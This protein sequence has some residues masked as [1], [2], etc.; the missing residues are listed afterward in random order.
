MDIDVIIA[1]VIRFSSG[2]SETDAGVFGTNT[3]TTGGSVTND[4]NTLT[5]KGNVSTYTQVSESHVT[6]TL[7]G[8]RL[9]EFFLNKEYSWHFLSFYFEGHRHIWLR[10]SFDSRCT[11]S[12]AL[13]WG[14]VMKTPIDKRIVSA[15]AHQWLDT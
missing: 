6:A 1:A 15:H 12:P 4:V 2:I 7:A 8:G 11:G 3:L 13:A 14:Y 10:V 9:E 5:A